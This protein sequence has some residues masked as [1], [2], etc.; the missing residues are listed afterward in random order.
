M[1]Q[2]QYT[3]LKL[4]EINIFTN[5][6]PCIPKPSHQDLLNEQIQLI[7]ESTP[8]DEPCKLTE[9]VRI[10]TT[11]KSRKHSNTVHY[12]QA[13][14]V[15]NAVLLHILLLLIGIQFIKI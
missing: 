10:S 2:K 3:K 11:N 8:M 14:Q 4:N 15:I 5:F 1:C 13:L 12:K 6:L 7:K 9:I